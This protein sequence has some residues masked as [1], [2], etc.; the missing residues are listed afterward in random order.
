MNA[1]ELLV[2]EVAL[3]SV[4]KALGPLPSTRFHTHAPLRGGP[5]LLV[6]SLAALDTS[7]GRRSLEEML[8]PKARNAVSVVLFAAAGAV[9]SIASVE[10]VSQLAHWLRRAPYIAPDADAVRRLIFARR[11][12][13]EQELIASASIEEGRLVV[14]SCEPRRF[15]VAVS[16]IPV[17]ADMPADLLQ[18]FEV[19]ASGSRIRWPHADIDLDLDTIR[20]SADPA[21]RRQHEARARHEAS[22][23]GKAIRRLREERGL[24]QTNI[25]GLTERQVRRLEEGGT[26]PQIETLRHLAA[27]HGMEVDGYLNEL[28][29]RSR[30]S[31]RPA[32]AKVPARA[33]PAHAR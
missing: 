5:Q 28:A 10:A 30:A 20:E 27:A 23:Y 21:V 11:N 12:H 15:E 1:V 22:R 4:K 24:K 25:P 9:L 16:E 13:A 31:R 26:V 32:P 8:S 18:S 33:R 7:E 6:S 17:L 29:K 19:S 2:P 3:S 14:W